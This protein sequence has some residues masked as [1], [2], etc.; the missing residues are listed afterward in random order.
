M[1]KG[2]AVEYEPHNIQVNSVH[3]DFTNPPTMIEA[4]DK[5][6]GE[7]LKDIP[8]GRLAE[9]R[10]ESNLVLFLAIG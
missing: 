9:A 1:T 4:A 3:P 10:E 2:I 6:G 5:E 8:L 7:A